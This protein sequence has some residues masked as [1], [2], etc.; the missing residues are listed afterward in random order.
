MSR[1]HAAGH[2][3]PENPHWLNFTR[4]DGDPSNLPKNTKKIVT[5]GQVNYMREVDMDESLAIMWRVNVGKELATRM[6]LPG[7]P[8]PVNAACGFPQHFLRLE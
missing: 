6:G 5:N 1:R 7:R 4:S 2:T 3:L 8:T